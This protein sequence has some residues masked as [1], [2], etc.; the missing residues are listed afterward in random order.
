MTKL[1]F[2]AKGMGEPKTGKNSTKL[3]F[4]ILDNFNFKT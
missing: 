4:Q 1:F 2:G 3:D